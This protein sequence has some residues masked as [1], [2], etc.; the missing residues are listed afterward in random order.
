VR[1]WFVV[2][3]SVAIV[4]TLVRAAGFREVGDVWSSVER[5]GVAVAVACWWGALAVRVATWRR[6]L[7]ADAPPL[8]T[9]ASPLALGFVLG[10]LLPAKS[11]E[12]AAA[13]LASRATGLPR[14][15]TL[16]VLTAERALHLLALL[17]TFLPSAATWAGATLPVS[18]LLLLLASGALLAPPFLRAAAPAASRLP[19]VGG[20]LRLYLDGLAALLRSRRALLPPLGLATLFWLLQYVSLWAI[21][22]AG[23]LPVNPVEA[24]AVAGAAIL[25]GTLSMLPLGTQDGISAAA[26]AGLGV[27][28]ARGFALSLLHS[29]ISL[30]CGFVVAGLAAVVPRRASR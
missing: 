19:G 3:A 4:L 13:L 1:R 29:A 11:G 27:P 24:A 10:H 12:P 9:L 6:L 2:V 26:L 15:R 22:R 30:G 16:S 25:G 8:R 5:R 17:A 28:L 14:A 20:A 18:I 21:L 23:G 7:G